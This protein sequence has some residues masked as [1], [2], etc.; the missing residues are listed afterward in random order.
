MV[1]EKRLRTSRCVARPRPCRGRG[2]PSMPEFAFPAH[3]PIDS[4][5][6]LEQMTGRFASTREGVPEL[7]KNSKDQ[8]SRLGIDA[9]TDRQIVVLTDLL[10]RRLGVLDFAGAA[11]LDF[12]GWTTWSSRT[13]SRRDLSTEIEG[14][15]GN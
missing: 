4:E 10:G 13:A 15:H 3:I 12:E 14:G 5:F 11:K 8:Y 9:K 7:I 6:S 2:E 1:G